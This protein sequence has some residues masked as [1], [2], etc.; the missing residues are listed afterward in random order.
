MIPMMPY[1]HALGSCFAGWSLYSGCSGVLIGSL[2]SDT[3]PQQVEIF[4]GNWERN[5]LESAF[6]SWRDG[7]YCGYTIFG[8]YGHWMTFHSSGGYIAI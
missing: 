5:Y 7:G 4:M 2:V 6:R 3:F 1:S 8:C